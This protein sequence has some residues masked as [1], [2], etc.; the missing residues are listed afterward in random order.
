MA[1]LLLLLAA[2]AESS[3]R[4]PP[5]DDWARALAIQRDGKVVVVG[6][7]WAQDK[8]RFAL[9]RYTARGTLDPSFGHNGKVISDLGSYGGARAVAIQSDG[10]I[11]AS[12]GGA[13]AFVLARYT[14]HGRLDSSFG[15]NG[16]VRTSFGRVTEAYAVAV[17]PDGRIVAAG[18][19][20]GYLALA[21]YRANGVLDPTFGDGGTVS[22]RGAAFAMA[23]QRDGAIIVA[24]GDSVMRSY[25]A[26]GTL[27]MSFGKGGKASTGYGEGSQIAIQP[28]GAI[29]VP[30]LKPVRAPASPVTFGVTRYTPDGRL[31]LS[32]G[33]AGRA[34][35]NFGRASSCP[36]DQSTSTGVARG[37]AIEPDG[38]V[39]VVGYSSA[40]VMC[41]ERNGLPHGSAFTLAR[42]NT[43]GSLDSRLGSK[44]TVVTPF[45][46][47][48]SSSRAEAVATRSD[49]RIV[50]AGL[51]G[52][53]GHGSS[54]ALA[55]YTRDGRLDRRF[56]GSGKVLTNFGSG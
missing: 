29:V 56:G 14:A 49:G 39:V 42:Y 10:K 28:D 36:N 54:F 13:N 38:K 32:F 3:R 31:D 35:T 30:T 33:D 25:T 53:F 12:G 7:S 48:G 43:D 1:A 5:S 2:P 15:R 22:T 45:A 4:A 19:A 6:L 16:I 55:R 8:W 52:S 9:A 50:V 51:G 20:G 27:D 18:G 47:Y 17:Q 11:I 40:K 41:D 21:R 23:I 46:S 34:S 24:G 26:R 37:V 44:G